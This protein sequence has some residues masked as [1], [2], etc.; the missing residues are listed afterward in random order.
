LDFLHSLGVLLFFMCFLGFFFF[1]LAF[2]SNFFFVF[3]LVLF[4]LRIGVV[5]GHGELD[6]LCLLVFIETQGDQYQ[7]F[8]WLSKLM[9]VFEQ[10]AGLQE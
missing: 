7:F 3:L 1:D 9:R 5:L 2:G 4:G 8:Q 6:L 10:E